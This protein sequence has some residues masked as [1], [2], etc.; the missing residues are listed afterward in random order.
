MMDRLFDPQWILIG[1]AAL[2][3]IAFIVAKFPQRP[4]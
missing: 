2:A 3:L 1:G 4:K